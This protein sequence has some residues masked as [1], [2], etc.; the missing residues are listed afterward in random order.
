MRTARLRRSSAPAR[1]NHP[2]SLD[3]RSKGELSAVVV[4]RKNPIPAP[5]KDGSCQAVAFD[6]RLDRSGNVRAE[7]ATAFSSKSDR[8]SKAPQTRAPIQDA[9]LPRTSGFRHDPV[10]RPD[11]AVDSWHQR[12]AGA[13][14][15]S[16]LYLTALYWSSVITPA[17]TI[18]S[19]SIKQCTYC[20]VGALG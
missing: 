10:S 16:L 11:R 12:R 15:N 2:T 9:P 14:S 7:R 3:N 17:R 19:A 5:S 8:N 4:E 20:W 13:A 1:V 6:A 18:L